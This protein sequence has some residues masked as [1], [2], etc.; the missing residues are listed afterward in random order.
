MDPNDGGFAS[1]KFLFCV[2][3]ATAIVI[4]GLLAGTVLT[5]ISAVLTEIYGALLGI[6]GLY[7]T[8]NISNSYLAAKAAATP[9]SKAPVKLVADKKPPPP[10][11]TPEDRE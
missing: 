6:S 7:L 11:D 4:I 10:T 9:T 1:R 3:V 5:G 8:G 2:V